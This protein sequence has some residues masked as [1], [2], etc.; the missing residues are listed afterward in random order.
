LVWGLGHESIHDVPNLSLSRSICGSAQVGKRMLRYAAGRRRISAFAQRPTRRRSRTEST[1]SRQQYRLGS[2]GCGPC[3]G[4]VSCRAPRPYVARPRGNSRPRA[5]EPSAVVPH[6]WR[7]S[8][9]L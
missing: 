5:T 7:K 1:G 3:P 8:Q 6:A 9:R 4:G 2:R